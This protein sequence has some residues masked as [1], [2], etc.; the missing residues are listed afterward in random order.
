MIKVKTKVSGCFPIEEG[1]RDYLK[2]MPSIDRAHRQRYNVC[3][4]IKK[5]ISG[6]SD[7]IFG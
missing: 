4:A 5:A 6:Y 2:I 7:F 1:V 3:D